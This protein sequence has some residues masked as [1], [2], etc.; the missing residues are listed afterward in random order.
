MVDENIEEQEEG[1]GGS[2]VMKT[3]IVLLAVFLLEGA[4]IMVTMFLTKPAVTI[5][6]GEEEIDGGSTRT[7]EH[8]VVKERFPNQQQGRTFLYDT[9]VWIAVH[10]KDSEDVKLRL[11]GIKA[12]V[13][14]DIKTIFR[15]ANP[16]HFSEPTHA[17]L[18]RQVKAQLDKHFG[19]D[20]SGEPI[21]KAV[22]FA[23]LTPYPLQY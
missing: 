9:E 16:G 3:V 20:A 14:T 4:T 13:T 10:Q 23:R 8:L 1:A 15:L 18:T 12:K 22:M 19:V 21:V 5:N 6:E 7:V 11:D 2:T 17:T